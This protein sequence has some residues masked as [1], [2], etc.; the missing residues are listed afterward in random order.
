MK[1]VLLSG[2]NGSNAKEHSSASLSAPYVLEYTYRRSTGPVIGRF[3]TALRDGRIE[4]VRTKSGKVLV[5]PAEYDPETGDAVGDAVEVGQSGVV[6]TW[7]WVTEPRRGHPLA[8]PFAWALVKLDGADT[9]MLHAVDAGS[10]DA[11]RTGMRVTARWRAERVGEIRDLE[12]F[13][14]EGASES[15]MK[16]VAS[17][18]GGGA[19]R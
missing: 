10:M 6:T 17:P 13:V 9:A 1:H 15:R 18:G 12:C 11:M 14:P 16:H 19:K 7:S 4:G 8:K 3:L 5:P 2:M